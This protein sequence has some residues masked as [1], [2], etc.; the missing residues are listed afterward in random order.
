MAEANPQ[1]DAV[2]ATPAGAVGEVS[3]FTRLLDKEF[4]PK[5]DRAKEAIG[6]AVET[7]AQV[8]LQNTALIGSDSVKTIESMI[9]TLDQKI[10]QQLNHILHHPDFRALE[11]SWRGLR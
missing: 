1:V 11:G 7:L 6:R 4:K 2:A 10:S 8:A 9:A 5:T 3:A